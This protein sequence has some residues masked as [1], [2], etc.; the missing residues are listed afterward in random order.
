VNSALI[1]YSPAALAHVSLEGRLQAAL[2]GGDDYELCFT[3][4]AQ[5]AE[6]LH[7][8]A[9]SHNLGLQKIGEITPGSELRLLDGSGI[10]ILNHNQAY[11]HFAPRASEQ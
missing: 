1:P 6:Q 7:R 11:Q 10:E 2:Y 9:A 4:P 3:A 8:I 5:V